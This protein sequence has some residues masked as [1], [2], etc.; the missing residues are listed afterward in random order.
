MKEHRSTVYHSV[1]GAAK[2]ALS[3]NFI[4]LNYP[5]RKEGN[6]LFQVAEKQF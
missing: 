1:Q 4:A 3:G 2:A 6:V 5:I